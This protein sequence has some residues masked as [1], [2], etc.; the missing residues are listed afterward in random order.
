MDKIRRHSCQSYTSL[1][2]KI[3]NDERISFKA[4]GIFL[5]LW[6]KP[7]EWTVRI[8]DICN[9]GKEGKSAVYSA[10]QELENYG[11]LRRE[12]YY[13]DGKIAGIHYNLYEDNQHLETLNL[14]NLNE[15]N[16]THS[17]E[18][19]LQKKEEVVNTKDSNCVTPKCLQN[20]SKANA[21][22]VSEIVGYL[23]QQTGSN[24]KATTP[25]TI[26]LIKDRQKEGFT[27]EDFKIVIDKKV[28]LWAK[29]LKMQAFL[30]PETLFGTKFE[31]YLNEVVTQAKALHAQGVLSES[32]AKA[33]SVAEE[34]AREMEAKQ[35]G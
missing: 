11:Y 13:E 19:I 20:T 8:Q 5:Y 18:R 32:G 9:H 17:K 15:E 10:L 1:S 4:K 7:D 21:N 22:F 31:S 26:K 27:L 33:M 28:L 25:K 14:E 3:I 24:Y 34:W 29:D 16:R 35:N 2:N 12:R 23:N 30:R 6:A